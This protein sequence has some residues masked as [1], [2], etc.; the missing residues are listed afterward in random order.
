MNKKIIL[1]ATALLINLQ[2]AFAQTGL[3]SSE[4]GQQFAIT[5]III[6]VAI[7]IIR[8]I[9]TGKLKFKTF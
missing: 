6:I 7:I 9:A 1:Y 8:S 5:G 3:F 2:I 4:T